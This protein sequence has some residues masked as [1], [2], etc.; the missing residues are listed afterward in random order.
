MGR[1]LSRQQRDML[2]D[3]RRD[4]CIQGGGGPAR[5]RTIRRLV[6]RGLL[7][8][9]PVYDNH[10]YKMSLPREDSDWFYYHYLHGF[11]MLTDAGRAVI[12]SI[13]HLLGESSLSVTTTPP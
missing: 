9:Y 10:G 3:V 6:E 8:W 11:Y 4:G 7:V 5:C 2:R 13:S 12:P 1:G